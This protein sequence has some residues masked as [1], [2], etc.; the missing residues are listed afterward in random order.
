MTSGQD[1]VIALGRSLS[2]L[3]QLVDMLSINGKD[4]AET[5]RAYRVALA[6]EILKEREKG[7]PVTIIGDV[8]RGKPQIAMLKLKRDVAETMYNS[9]LEAINACKLEI[10]V[11]ESQID[12]EWGRQ[13]RTT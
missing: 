3:Q 13:R 2:R 7:T 6:Q 5:E 4:K 1:L 10:R 11:I 9:N 12:R 8:C